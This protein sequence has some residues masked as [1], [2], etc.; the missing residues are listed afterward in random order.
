MQ[1]LVAEPADRLAINER[2]LE[3]ATHSRDPAARDW[4]ASL[5]TD[6]GMVHADAR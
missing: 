3:L 1:A 6:I 4:D 5:L 2:A